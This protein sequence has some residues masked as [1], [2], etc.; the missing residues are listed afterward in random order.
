M[1][2]PK[3]LSVDLVLAIHDEATAAFGG[4]SGVRDIALLESALAR[5]RHRSA[6][7][8]ATTIFELAAACGVGIARNHPFIDGNKR[9]A[10]LATRA[11][12]FLNGWELEP[13]EPDEVHVMCGVAAGEMDEAAFA[14]WLEANSRRRAR[15]RR[16]RPHRRD[17]SS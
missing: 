13:S 16:R 6:Y 7:R 1:K 15:L 14:S 17:R 5:A 11:F 4:A 10:L 12:L 8:H 2:E 9:T 3:W